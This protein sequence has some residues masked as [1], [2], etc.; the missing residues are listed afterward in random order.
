MTPRTLRCANAH[1]YLGFVA[2]ILAAATYAL[3][4]RD[5]QGWELWGALAACAAGVAWGCC[6]IG[7]KFELDETGVS[8]RLF[9]VRVQRIAWS[10]A[11]RINVQEARGAEIESCAITV[12]NGKTTLLLSSDLLPLDDVQRLAADM[13][14]EGLVCSRQAKN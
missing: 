11:T 12:D 6:Y 1:L 4:C 5:L 7:L 10:E 2:L 8:R 9:G 14:K 3:F 13:R